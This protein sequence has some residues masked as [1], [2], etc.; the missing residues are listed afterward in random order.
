MK[1]IALLENRAELLHLQQQL[2]DAL[3]DDCDIALDT[4]ARCEVVTVTLGK[5]TCMLMNT[6]VTLDAHKNAGLL[7][8]RSV[9]GRV[10]VLAGKNNWPINTHSLTRVELHSKLSLK[11]WTSFVSLEAALRN[12]EGF[13]K[14]ESKSSITESRTELLHLQQRLIDDLSDHISV[15]LVNEDR[16]GE[17]ICIG[18]WSDGPTKRFI[19]PA[20][21]EGHVDYAPNPH[22]AW[23]CFSYDGIVRLLI[24]AA[25]PRL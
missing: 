22:V 7:L 20:S 8:G 16:L 19:K 6:P 4:F 15:D 2:I 5:A 9:T 11:P 13:L 24:K 25:S 21:I 10:S 23:T 12:I 3:P 18:I 17:V 1:L 14:Q